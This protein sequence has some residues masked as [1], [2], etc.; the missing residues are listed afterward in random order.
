MKRKS[1]L[2]MLLVALFVPLA[3]NA[4]TKSLRKSI[5]GSTQLKTKVSPMEMPSSSMLSQME[6][7]SMRDLMP[8]TPANEGGNRAITAVGDYELVTSSQTDW[9]GDYVIAYVASTTSATVM[10]NRG[11]SGTNTYGTG[12][13]VTF[14]NNTLPASSVANYNVTI[15]KD[16]NYYTLK[17]GNYYLGA[18]NGNY[19]LFSTTTP[20]QDTYRW[21]ISYSSNTLTITNASYTT[22]KLLWNS[23]TSGQ[24]FACYTS[25]QQNISLFKKIESSCAKPT[26][27]A[28]D[29]TSITESAATVTWTA[30]DAS[31]W[32]LRYKKSSASTWTTVPPLTV[33][34][35]DFTGLDEGSAYDVQVQAN[36][37]GGELSAW[38]DAVSFM[39]ECGVK[40]LPFFCGFESADEWGCV[41]GYNWATNTNLSTSNYRTGNY[42]FMFE[43]NGSY[44][45]LI[46]P[47]FDGTT[48][49]AV[50]FYYRLRSSSYQHYFMLGYATE[51]DL[52][53]LTFGTEETAT[54]QS[55]TEYT[56]TFPVG[57]RFVVLACG[58]TS[59]TN[60]RLF[61]DDFNFT[62]PT[63]CLTPDGLEAT[64]I[65]SN[66]ANLSWN[67]YG[68]GSYNV[69]YREVAAPKFAYDFE[70]ATPWAV[71]DFSPCTTYD[72]D[73]SATGGIQ[74]TEFTNQGYTGS[75]IAF[76]NGLSDN[77]SSH[78]GNAFG[79]C[80]YATTPPNND[81]FILPSMTIER[82]DVFTFWARSLSSSYLETLSAGIYRGTGSFS[83]T[84]VSS[85]TVA[86]DWTKYSYDLSAYAGQTIQLAIQCNSNDK[87][88]LYLDDI[89]VTNASDSW[90]E[91]ITNVTS[92]YTSITG[93]NPDTE[94]EWQVQS[95]CGNGTS[96]WSASA[97]FT[98]ASLCDAPDGL[99]TTN[100]TAV[101]ATLSWNQSLNN[102]NV[103]YG[104]PETKFSYDFESATPF[105]VD[106]FSPCTTYDGDGSGTY[107]IEDLEFTNQQ[108]TGAFIAFQ[109]GTVSN[110]DAHGGNAF[111]AC[112]SATTPPNN[113][114]FILPE[115]TIETGDVFS[116][117]AK[118]Y[119]S[120]YPESFKVGVYSSNGSFSSYLAGSASASI[121]PTTNW[122]QYSYDLSA[123]NGQ[124]IQLAIQCV[125]NDAFIFCID[126]LI[127]SNP[128]WSDP[129]SCTGGSYNLEGL[130]LATDYVWQVQ[131][132]NCDGNGNTTDWSASASFTTLDGI[133]VESITAADVTVAVGA[134]AT[135]TAT[136]LPADA[137]NPAVTYTSN[138]TEIAT[139]E[140]NV[141]T[142]VAPGNTTVTIAA[143]DGS[144][145]STTINV[146][147]TGIDV[148][149]ITTSDVTVVNG[150]TATISYTV[151][152]NN[153]SDP[154]VTFTSANTAIAT[155]DASG[156]VTGVGVGTTT[157]T[158]AS[159]SNP[160]VTATVNVT[161]T[162]NP[163]AVQFTVN[164]PANAH[165][166][167]VITVEGVLAAPTSG[168]YAGFT[169]LILDITYDNTA[170]EF[171]TGSITNGPVAQ[172]AQQ[173][174]AMLTQGTL[175]NA[176]QL[177]IIA[178]SNNVTTQDV[179]FS[180]QFTVLEGAEGSYTFTAIPHEDNLSYE[181]ELL[182]YE[183]TPST[184]V[185]SAF[186]RYT[187]SIVGYDNEETGDLTAG[188]WYL[189]AS[190]MSTSV[191]PTA[192]NGFLTY[193]HDL[194]Y[195]DQTKELEW[196]NYKDDDDGGY[197]LV[198]GKGYLYASSK[199]VDLVFTGT[200]YSG[201]GEVELS[202]LTSNPTDRNM[203]GWNLVGNPF[204]TQNA[205]I[206]KNCYTMDNDDRLV[207]T[208]AGTPI[209]PMQGILVHTANVEGETLT[210]STQ[211]KNKSANLAL[212]LSQGR[213]I[214]DRAIVTFDESEAL[215]KFQ[216]REG[217]AKVFIPM[218]GKDYAVVS[219]QGQGEMPV[220]F[221]AEENGRYTLSFNA[222]EVEFNYLHLIDNKTGNDVDLLANPSYSFDART[223]DYASRFKLVFVTGTANDNN[224]A[225]FSNGG[226]VINN[227][228]NATLQVIDVNG[229]ILKSESINGCA[230]VNVNAAAGVYMLR[231]INGDNVK[232]QKVVVE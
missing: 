53:D 169:A 146:T 185:V 223:T 40:S 69:R 63:G 102:Y 107:G 25:A 33:A 1:L 174:G 230:N 167:D 64:D 130:T 44:Q 84:F 182:P 136:V 114:F 43:G 4:Q 67:N 41:S 49:V 168:N 51:S 108:Y 20:S 154:S 195:F 26:D 119:T 159:V 50:S 39:T 104:T 117:W 6:L 65:T 90:D 54:S 193:D 129:I 148:T 82:G 217:S 202:Y 166:G 175:D 48:A 95:N 38:T 125:S 209:H 103:R 226:F 142:G 197:D 37:G 112:F 17:F 36:C 153:A 85:T 11:G 211:A 215:P 196:I 79:A 144:N 74:N 191:T 22:R 194:Y 181:T 3:V 47:E 59:G 86:V 138:N 88:A 21:T 5:N 220:S 134:T 118:E 171:V 137:S 66:S 228:G 73:G 192:D 208:V 147:V 80:F 165:P 190:P 55:Y 219:A 18:R 222:E 101:S 68:A 109:N 212:S 72:G 186:D 218:E 149:G 24:R 29:E 152:P 57:T 71:D 229:R 8:D 19:L 27:L 76:Q 96:D 28:V 81:W 127:V 205:T 7:I 15:A 172:Q 216:F 30:G 170:F 94:Y 98:T 213:G 203:Y 16:G 70:S 177:A 62:I 105:A 126:D 156:V 184:V 58:A 10:S 116:F 45:Y 60:Y 106:D 23:A 97:T 189:I 128:H 232:T 151:A 231:L 32:N 140:G 214:L 42:C 145:V 161:V 188:H 89:S 99:S 13:S 227:E 204:A 2:I 178:W 187:K 124:T 164:A 210:F 77:L 133:L 83:T 123:Y 225:F 31:Q 143:T 199:D 163:N 35:Y 87:F 157:I 34:Y 200:A 150:Q 179:V 120:S 100:I 110:L 91:I 141:V 158:I 75:F 9:S 14:S 180:A 61:V 115:L 131:G 132:V 206:T 122:T 113:D 160:E 221:K 224:F 183:A 121:T 139:V 12:T 173:T 207:E 198:S 56:A 201:D 92:P 176:V 52:S 46:F 93:L 155:V 111:G 162:S 135:I 78:G